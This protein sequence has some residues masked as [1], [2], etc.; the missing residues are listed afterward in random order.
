MPKNHP[1]N[2][3]ARAAA[4]RVRKAVDGGQPLQAALAAANVKGAV[5]ESINGTRADLSKQGQ[6]ISPPLSLMFAMKKGTAKTLQ[7]GGNRGWYVVHLG[8]VIKGDAR[9]NSD[10]LKAR[11]QEMSGLLQQEYGAQLIA[12]AVKAVG[13]EKNEDGIKELRTR[14]TNRDGN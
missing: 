12:A 1:T 5:I 13:V 7:G 3:A 6:P 4:E 11:K 10:M 9:G 2:C 14:L 8:E